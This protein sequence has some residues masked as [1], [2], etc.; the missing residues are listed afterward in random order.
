MQPFPQTLFL[1]SHFVAHLLNSLPLFL[2]L[3]TINK[4]EQ[5]IGTF[6]WQTQSNMG[7]FQSSFSSST[8]PILA[9]L[10]LLLLLMLLL[11]PSVSGVG[12]KRIDRRKPFKI[13]VILDLDSSL[14]DQM[15]MAI[16]LACQDANNISSGSYYIK[17]RYVNSGASPLGA[18]SAG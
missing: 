13:G 11:I 5:R 4:W 9:I 12:T 10:K 16:E 15:R 6:I 17:P 18:I 8:R 7:F 1:E 2:S 3:Q 14:G